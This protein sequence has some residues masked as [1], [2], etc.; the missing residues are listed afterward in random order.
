MPVF[1]VNGYIDAPNVYSFRCGDRK[2]AF[3]AVNQMAKS[4]AKDILF[5]HHNMT[6]SVRSKL[7][8]YQEALHQNGLTVR[9]EYICSCSLDIQE[10]AAEV[11]RL[12]EAG[13]KFDG[14]IATED[15]IAV[16]VL[17]YAQRHGIA[18]PDDLCVIGFGNTNL[19]ESCT[20]ELSSVDNSVEAACVAAVSMLIHKL[21]NHRIPS[22]L[23]VS[24]AVVY[25][26][27]TR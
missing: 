3:Q 2:G 11:E 7:E 21:K 27:T 20:P 24:S 9:Q 18:V 14:V 15:S 22:E 19:T 16:G 26:K 23:T 1:L 6:G 12:A 13:L 4:G 5:L 10:S 17:K 8:G 25:R